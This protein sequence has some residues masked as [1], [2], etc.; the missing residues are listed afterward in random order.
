M[1]RSMGAPRRARSASS[2]G[3]TRS[4]ARAPGAS[5]MAASP[6]SCH[7]EVTQPFS[8]ATQRALRTR[9]A[10]DIRSGLPLRSRRSP[11]SRY[12]CAGGE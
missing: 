8:G 6:V 9:I 5:S 7:W 1:I 2:Q 3:C 10:P 12:D 11:S 4:Y